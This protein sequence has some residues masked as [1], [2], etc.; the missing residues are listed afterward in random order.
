MVAGRQRERET[1]GDGRGIR[2]ISRSR[3]AFRLRVSVGG[4]ICPRVAYRGGTRE[5]ARGERRGETRR[6]GG[7]SREEKSERDGRA[8]RALVRVAA[9]SWAQCGVSERW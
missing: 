3:I 7:L 9:A 4:G 6:R 5:R 8:Y 1:G 2:A